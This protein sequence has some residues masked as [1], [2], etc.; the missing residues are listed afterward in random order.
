MPANLS[1]PPEV[2]AYTE[3]H[4]SSDILYQRC[5]CTSGLRHA[6]RILSLLVTLSPARSPS[7]DYVLIIIFYATE[8]A[9][10]RIDS[11]RVHCE[12]PAKDL[13]IRIKRKSVLVF[14]C[15]GTE[16]SLG[17]LL[18]VMDLNIL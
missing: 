8:N 3:L 4:Q 5:H 12:I 18:D 11:S 1:A 15:D 17:G 2:N 13:V 9:S 10:D 14:V 16:G 6:R 7:I